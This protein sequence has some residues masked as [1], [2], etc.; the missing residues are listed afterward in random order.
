VLVGAVCVAAQVIL[1][2]AYAPRMPERM[3]THFDLAG[4][5]NGWMARRIALL[6]G[7]LIAAAVAVLLAV[8]PGIRRPGG[9]GAHLLAAPAVLVQAVLLAAFWWM[10]GRNARGSGARDSGT[11]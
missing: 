6:M 10:Y 5:P 9:P 8:A 11:R 3:A 7:P 4:R 2:V 1:S